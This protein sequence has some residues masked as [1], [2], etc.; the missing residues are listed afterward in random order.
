[1]KNL[2]EKL[3]FIKLVVLDYDGVFT[4]GIIYL[5]SNKS[6]GFRRLTVKEMLLI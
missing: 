6:Q 1:M 3:K 2:Y 5:D 4:E